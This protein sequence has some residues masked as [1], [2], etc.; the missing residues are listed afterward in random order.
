MSTRTWLKLVVCAIQA[1]QIF[2][3]TES[4]SRCIFNTETRDFSIFHNEKIFRVQIGKNGNI[5]STLPEVIN[6]PST[7]MKISTTQTSLTLCSENYQHY[8]QSSGNCVNNKCTCENGRQIHYSKCSENGG[9]N[10][11]SCDEGFERI[12]VL[13]GIFHCEK[14]NL[15]NQETTS[16]ASTTQRPITNS[17]T[18]QE[19]TTQV[20]ST[21]ILT[22]QKPEISGFFQSLCRGGYECKGYNEKFPLSCLGGPRTSLWLTSWLP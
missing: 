8:N 5:I 21:Q 10:C 22:T 9:E 6:Q 4:Q 13:E 7:T 15:I 19:T 14:P 16:Q 20:P 11:R 17:T 2:T 12:E 3:S 1:R 18:T